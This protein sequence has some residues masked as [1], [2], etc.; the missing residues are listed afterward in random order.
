MNYSKSSNI[1]VDKAIEKVK[2][3]LYNVL[4]LIGSL[5]AYGRVYKNKR[6]NNIVLEVFKNPD[7]EDV[8][9]MDSSRFFFVVDERKKFDDDPQ[10]DIDIVFMVDLNHF[11]PN[12][13]ERKDEEFKAIVNTS[14]KQ[15]N[16]NVLNMYGYERLESLLK[17]LQIG[18]S[19]NFDHMHPKLIFT[20]SGELNY[21]LNTCI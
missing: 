19:L 10:S 2:N 9:G 3:K 13:N 5:D 18:K 11:Y 15:T 12:A 20:V 7:Y 4:S 14:L 6:G 1:G 17:G 21:N 8:M 16:F